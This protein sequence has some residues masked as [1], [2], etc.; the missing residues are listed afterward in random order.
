MATSLGVVATAV[1]L[2]FT[3]AGAALG[4]V[5]LLL[6]FFGVLAAL[7]VVYLL[8]VE[9]VKRVFTAG[10]RARHEGGCKFQAA[11]ATVPLEY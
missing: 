8:A 5:P 4:L 7:V 1:A 6:E 9:A 10:R 3:M 2:P 11:S